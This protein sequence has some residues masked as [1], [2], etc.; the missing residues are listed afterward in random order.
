MLVTIFRVWPDRWRQRR[1][2]REMD[3]EQLRDLGISRREAMREGQKPFW[4]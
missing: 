3:I 4:R 1:D 2:L